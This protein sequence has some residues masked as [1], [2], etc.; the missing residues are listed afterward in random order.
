MS[1][2]F[3]EAGGVLMDRPDINRPGELLHPD[4]FRL[5]IPEWRMI[6]ALRVVM[7]KVP[8]LE[9]YIICLYPLSLERI[10]ADYADWFGRYVP[11]AKGLRY[12]P[13]GEYFGSYIAL[14][15]NDILLSADVGSLA[16]FSFG[17]RLAI[18]VDTDEAAVPGIPCVRTWDRSE[19]I[20]E[21]LIELIQ[22]GQRYG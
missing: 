19:L 17:G 13:I 8:Q 11:H 14:K 7:S 12:L 9:V 4:Y 22:G 3:V 18:G 2:L 6:H 20:A 21:R 16:V 1:R 10:K 15:R 5:R